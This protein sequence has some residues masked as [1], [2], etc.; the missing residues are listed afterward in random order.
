MI[1]KICL[2][3]VVCALLSLLLR[4]LG[5]KSIPLVSTL[6]LIMIFSAV[7][8]GLSDLFGGISSFISQAGVED[9]VKSCLRAVGLG[10]IFGFTAEIC[11]SL[12]EG[13]VAS[14]VTLA[15][16]IQIFLVAYPY[17]EKIIKLSTELLK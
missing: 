2:F 4:E 17:I 9:G 16:K 5:Y 13:T 1:P 15:G 11:S 7:G 3:A 12:G 8:G 6:A 14:A 10:Y